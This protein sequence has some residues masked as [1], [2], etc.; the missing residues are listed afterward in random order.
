MEEKTYKSGERWEDNTLDTGIE[1]AALKVRTVF[2]RDI[3]RE[4]ERERERKRKR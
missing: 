2:E 3:K 1:P 4:R